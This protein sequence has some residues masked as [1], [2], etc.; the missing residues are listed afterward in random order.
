MVPLLK[1]WERGGKVAQLNRLRAGLH[2]VS[3]VRLAAPTN[4]DGTPI[5]QGTCY[6]RPHASDASLVDPSFKPYLPEVFT[7]SCR[8]TWD[9][10]GK[11]A[12]EKAHVRRCKI[13]LRGRRLRA[14]L[15]QSKLDELIES[16]IH[17]EAASSMESGIDSDE[18]FWDNLDL[19]GTASRE[20]HFQQ[21]VSSKPDPGWNR[22]TIHSRLSRLRLC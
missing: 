19:A 17:G 14:T 4:V 11:S 18:E 5:G 21:S 16:F 3:K 15:E 1:P 6:A 9:D 7:N 12:K 22:A 10:G 8:R 20:T 13:R 2:P